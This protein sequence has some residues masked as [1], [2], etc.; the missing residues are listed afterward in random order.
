MLVPSLFRPWAEQLVGR[1][2]LSSGARVLDVACGTGIV[3]RL[4]AGRAGSAGHVVGVDVNPAM[5]AMARSVSAEVDWREGDAA[6]LPVADGET[7]DVVLCQQG[8]QFFPDR[9]KA[10]AEMRRVLAPGGRLGVSTWRS[11][12]EMPILREL[13]R[14]AERHLGPVMD[15]RHSFPDGREMENLLADAGFEDVRVQPITRTIRFDDGQVFISLNAMALAGMSPAAKDLDDEARKDVVG[16][17]VAD[18][19]SLLAAQNSGGGF[20]YEIGAN[21]ATARG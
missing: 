1:V 18:S 7:F 6:A 12:E 10:V 15:R 9:V 20:E 11:D 16:A 13:R 14:I 17:I 4:A 3:A 21:V 2:P 19:R 8:L 5:I